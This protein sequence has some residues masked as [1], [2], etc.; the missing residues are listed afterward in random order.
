LEKEK[1]IKPKANR[2]KEKIAEHKLIILKT[3]M[4]PKA[5]F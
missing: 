2:G 5:G 3:E 4:K 1:Q